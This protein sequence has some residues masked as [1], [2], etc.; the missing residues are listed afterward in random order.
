MAELPESIGN[1]KNLEDFRCHKNKLTGE[2]FIPSSPNETST[3]NKNESLAC[4]TNLFGRA[5]NL[6]VTSYSY[7]R[8]ADSV[9]NILCSSTEARK[10]VL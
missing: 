5:L 4:C 7:R 8:E 3:Q 6:A 2:Y 10:C 9:H 1:L